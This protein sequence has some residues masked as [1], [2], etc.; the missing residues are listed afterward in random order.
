MAINW[1]MSFGAGLVLVLMYA[2]AVVVSRRKLQQLSQRNVLLSR[3][4]IHALQEGLGAIRDVLLD[5]TQ[6]FYARTYFQADQPLRR[7]SADAIF[8]SSYP[9]FVLEPVGMALIAVVGYLYVRDQGV[10]SALPLLGALAL[11]AQRLLPVVQKVYEGWAQ[12]RHAK[13][14]LANIMQLLGQPLPPDWHLPPPAPFQLQQS[15][16]LE[17]VQ[18]AYAPELPM[19]LQ[20]LNLEIRRGERVGVIGSTG[21]GK[22]TM[23]DLFMGLLEPTGGRILVDGADLPDPSEPHRLQAWRATIAHVPQNIYLAIGRSLKTLPLVCLPIR[24]IWLWCSGRQSKRRFRY[25][26]YP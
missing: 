2:V 13:D 24:S 7:V 19:V 4:L 14:S 22:S 15:I 8:L 5:G 12:T 1:T 3:Q 21:S 18:F 26:E 23:L 17:G 6:A 11:G 25:R 20:D 10:E 16:R 9:R